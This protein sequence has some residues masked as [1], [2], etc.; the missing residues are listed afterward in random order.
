MK[1]IKFI[2]QFPVITEQEKVSNEILDSL[3]GRGCVES[4]AQGCV[5][6]NLKNN[7]KN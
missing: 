5:K 3:E 6:K 2:K 4:C 7:K 1:T